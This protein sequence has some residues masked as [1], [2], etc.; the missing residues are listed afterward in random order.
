MSRTT[1]RSDGDRPRRDHV[2]RRDVFDQVSSLWCPDSTRDARSCP[3]PRSR[4]PVSEST[5][6]IKL[7]FIPMLFLIYYIFNH[8]VTLYSIL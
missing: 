7:S 3:T 2:P 5:R 6:A 1:V 8:Y 4:S